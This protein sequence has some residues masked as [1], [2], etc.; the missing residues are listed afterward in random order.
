MKKFKYLFAMAIMCISAICITGCK[1]EKL[2]YTVELPTITSG[3]GYELLTNVDIDTE[4]N[5]FDVDSKNGYNISFAID[6]CYDINKLIIKANGEIVDFVKDTINNIITISDTSISSNTKITIENLVKK[7]LTFNFK[8]VEY[9]QDSIHYNSSSNGLDEINVKINDVVYT[10]NQ[11]IQEDLSFKISHTTELLFSAGCNTLD[12]YTNIQDLFLYGDFD[13]K[14]N[15]DNTTNSYPVPSTSSNIVKKVD[16]SILK[17]ES[18]WTIYSLN[19]SE[20][21]TIYINNGGL[22]IDQKYLITNSNLEFKTEQIDLVYGNEFN[23]IDYI[24]NPNNINFDD[25]KV[26]F[27][28]N[29]CIFDFAFRHP[30]DKLCHRHFNNLYKL[31][32]IGADV[33]LT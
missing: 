24:A 12:K 11:L 28:A 31:I 30:L 13:G 32:L 4:T 25:I 3:C 17:D 21:S 1:D 5:T 22:K 18:G 8:L 2:V 15:F 27:Y 14:L 6:D 19:I 16:N 20:N 26:D 33:A 23:P 10:I 7:E 29:F 9:S